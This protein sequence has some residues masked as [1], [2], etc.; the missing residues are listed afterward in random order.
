MIFSCKFDTKAYQAFTESPDCLSSISYDKAL[1]FI[2]SRDCTFFGVYNANE[3]AASL[4]CFVFEVKCGEKC[5]YGAYLCGFAQREKYQRQ[6][7]LRNL[8]T[9]CI[10]Q[11]KSKGA[12]VVLCAD[13]AP[14]MF[15]KQL[16]FNVK[17]SKIKMTAINDGKKCAFGFK[18][19]FEQRDFEAAGEIYSACLEKND[20]LGVSRTL[21]NFENR[22]ALSKSQLY[23]TNDAYFIYDGNSVTEFM[24]LGDNDKLLKNIARFFMCDLDAYTPI[25]RA[26]RAPEQ[27]TFDIPGLE[28]YESAEIT[29]EGIEKTVFAL[30][31]VLAEDFEAEDLYI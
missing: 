4:L 8:A 23:L 1:S 15:S 30:A 24:T 26:D 3:L 31:K 5:V 17:V 9:Y 19:A 14:D 6:D 20:I 12:A 18:K 16:G 29:D 7:A 11:L 25:A 13:N 27:L 28:E 10:T 22:V 21:R 2:N